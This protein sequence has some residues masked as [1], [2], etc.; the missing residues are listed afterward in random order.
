MDPDAELL[1]PT[2]PD[3]SDDGDAPEEA[4]ELDYELSE[5]DGA[6]P[7]DFATIRYQ[8][9]FDEGDHGSRNDE[10]ST[11][12]QTND[13]EANDDEAEDGEI[14][15]L[16][17]GEVKDDDDD[18]DDEKP[19]Q[20]PPPQF[21][22][23]RSPP[24]QS[25]SV[26]PTSGNSF[27]PA[28]PAASTGQSPGF[29]LSP[30]VR[31][32]DVGIC[33]FFLR[34]QCTWGSTCKFM[35]PQGHERSQW[36]QTDQQLTRTNTQWTNNSS[37]GGSTNGRRV[38]ATGATG[39]PVG[40]STA[41]GLQRRAPQS[42]FPPVSGPPVPLLSSAAPAVKE[43]DESAWERGLKQARELMKKAN[44]KREKEPDFE[45]KR[46]VLP[47]S[48]ELEIRKST[49]VYDEPD[50]DG[51]N[52][53]R[54]DRDVRRSTTNYEA[55]GSRDRGERRSYQSSRHASRD[56]D[57]Q[58]G[59]DR[60]RGG[61]NYPPTK[62][63]RG[64]GQGSGSTRDSNRDSNRDHH[65]NDRR[66]PPTDGPQ[67]LYP[68]QRNYSS[69]SSSSAN[70]SANHRDSTS[71]RNR[72]RTDAGL[73]STSSANR[74]RES[75][76]GGG[77]RERPSRDM[78]PRE[79]DDDR[80]RNHEYRSGGGDRGG[81]GGGRPL[82]YDRPSYDGR[83]EYRDPW[84]RDRRNPSTN[85]AS[86]SK[87][88]PVARKRST[89][90]ASTYSSK[91]SKSSSRSKSR[92]TYT[93]SRSS[94]SPDTNSRKR[95]ERGAPKVPSDSFGRIPKLTKDTAKAVDGVIS[96]NASGTRQPRT[97]SP[98]TPPSF[99]QDGALATNLSPEE[100]DV[101]DRQPIKM[102]IKPKSKM[103][104]YSKTELDSSPSPTR[105]TGAESISGTDEAPT[106]KK[107][108]LDDKNYKD[109]RREELL[110]QL[111]SVEEAIA[112]KRTKSV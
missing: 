30:N 74:S 1:E 13:D 48:D 90:S 11:E 103:R 81:G 98:M 10:M 73:S 16:E 51:E 68:S 85:A 4:G 39:R 42:S 33:K 95:K 27:P 105:S 79:R 49:N 69:S 71:G 89:S 55:G 87:E 23:R 77:E 93:S 32:E 67:V 20:P 75:G 24:K 3:G 96:S 21:F 92:E 65:H 102:T 60:S 52:D 104:Q 100:D 59:A 37:G 76:R 5:P 101:D 97:P 91:R 61:H 64:T 53:R 38:S 18:D 26:P 107:A 84:E 56:D 43:S 36:R 15:D 7:A 19:R 2:T 35:H 28:R 86:A 88:R 72:P 46:L 111:K 54:V 45:E 31:P 17:D 62:A 80:R 112:K 70:R 57:V 47:P 25:D 110:K 58:H 9:S 8:E 14:D 82:P 44:E 34:G 63:Y 29:G 41:G 78:P 22:N 6:S 109:T 83:G 94:A 12:Q 40:L 106:P 50:S 108:K 66:A 99:D